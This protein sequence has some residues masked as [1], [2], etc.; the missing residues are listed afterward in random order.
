MLVAAI[1][2]DSN[3]AFSEECGGDRRLETVRLLRKMADE[4]EQ[5][6]DH[7]VFHDING[8]RVGEWSDKKE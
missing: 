1:N 8:N 6:A 7:G 3:A 5:G 4:L 2:N